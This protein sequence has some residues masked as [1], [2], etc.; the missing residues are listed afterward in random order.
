MGRTS[1]STSIL[2]QKLCDAPHLCFAILEF[3]AIVTSRP[4]NFNFFDCYYFAAASWIRQWSFTMDKR[5]NWNICLKYLFSLGKSEEKGKAWIVSLLSI[6]K[7]GSEW[8]GKRR[9]LPYRL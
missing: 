5:A 2:S 8:V 6:I 3:I 1:I 4:Q 7:G 9:D